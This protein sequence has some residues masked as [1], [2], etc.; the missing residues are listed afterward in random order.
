MKIERTRNASR[1]IVF[2]VILR[3]VQIIIPFFMRSAVTYFI[4]IEYL[5]LD[6]LFKSLLQVL[7]LAELGVGSAMIYSM[8]K[9]IASDDHKSIC[10]LMKLYKYYYRIIGVIVLLIGLILFPFVPRLVKGDIPYGISIYILYSINLGAT[11]LS[12]WLFAYKNSLLDAHQRIDITS[13]VMLFTNLFLY[14]GQFILLWLTG[15][16]YLYVMA[17]LVTQVLTNLITAIIVSKMFPNY[18]PAGDL[19]PE[20]LH[21][22]NGRI[23]DLFTSKLGT[24]IVNSSDSIVISS[25][26]GLS[27]LAVYQNYYFVITSIISIVTIVFNAC[28]AGIG[29]SLIVETKEKNYN[30][31]KTFTFIIAWGA[32]VASTCLICMYQPFM[33][34]WMGADRLLPISAVTCFVVY[35]FVY[36]LNQLF[37]TYKDA[38]GIWHEDRFRP[39][40]TAGF[41]L[42]LNLIFVQFWGIYGVLLSTVIAMLLVGMPWLLH[43]LFTLLFNR[44]ELRSFV[45]DLLLYSIIALISCTTCFG[46]SNLIHTSLIISLII[47]AI[48]CLAVSNLLFLVFFHKRPEF[49]NSLSLGSRIISHQ[50]QS[51][52]AGIKDDSIS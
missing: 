3:S 8:Y 49:R 25:F 9:P 37:N 44:N 22:I 18:K 31:L 51:D 47:R 42:T 36:E 39:L 48:I 43:N 38:A 13:K 29:N 6:G 40:I 1:N 23:R 24:V 16:Y 30:D 33:E 26:L 46:L 10:A 45:A 52:K 4:G 21:S 50:K 2:G 5:G 34:L 17:M 20:E 27:V 11:V 41:N 28:L 12:Y 35:Y 15:N 32:G 14:S 19:S 7:N